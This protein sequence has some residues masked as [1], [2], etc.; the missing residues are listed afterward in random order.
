[1]KNIIALALVGLMFG[2]VAKAA[3]IEHTQG[4]AAA[5]ASNVASQV[6][7]MQIIINAS[8]LESL[9]IT[10]SNPEMTAVSTEV[11]QVLLGAYNVVDSLA[12]SAC[13]INS[14]GV[15]PVLTASHNSCASQAD[16]FAFSLKFDYAVELAGSFSVQIDASNIASG[17]LSQF[18][19][20]TLSMD[21]G[22]DS[23]GLVSTTG[24]GHGATGNFV[25]K[26]ELPHQGD[27]LR[28]N[29]IQ[30]DVVRL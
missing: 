24:L 27:S 18:D 7:A 23:S 29:I 2:G 17:S 22:L 9:K 14:P 28:E 16:R 12:A 6:D 11:G 26:G 15:A 25:W 30:L 21:G 19:N 10:V 5:S 1:M 20:Q 8:L 13:R 4:A 3:S